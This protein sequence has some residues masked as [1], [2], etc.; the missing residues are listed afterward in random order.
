MFD[1]SNL[2]EEGRGKLLVDRYFE[3]MNKEIQP[4]LQ[5]R[6]EQRLAQGHLTYP[7]LEPKWLPNSIHT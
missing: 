2:I 1:Y 7:Y 4:I 5:K 3:Q 6:N